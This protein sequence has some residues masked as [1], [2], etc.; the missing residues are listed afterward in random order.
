[1][2]A[3]GLVSNEEI[4]GKN[5]RHVLALKQRCTNEQEFIKYANDNM[6]ALGLTPIENMGDTID[7]ALSKLGTMAGTVAVLGKGATLAELALATTAVEKIAVGASFYAT[8]YV[9]AY[10]GSFAVATGKYLSCG[11]SIADA[12]AFIEDNN[13]KFDNAKVFFANNPEIL[14]TGMANREVFAKRASI[15]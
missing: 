4:Y 12:F 8:F 15:A 11:S 1:M 3:L 7:Q 2:G 13:I 14:N 6:K 10:I 5:G 9:G